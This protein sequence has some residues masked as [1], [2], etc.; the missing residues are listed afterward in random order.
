MERWGRGGEHWSDR[1]EGGKRELDQQGLTFE[2]SSWCIGIG[3]PSD[4]FQESCGQ[5]SL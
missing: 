2:F 3:E 4:G 1:R 5:L